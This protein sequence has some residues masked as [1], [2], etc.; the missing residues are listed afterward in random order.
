MD[1]ALRRVITA[2]VATVSVAAVCVLVFALTAGSTGGTR[3]GVKASRSKSAVSQTDPTTS[4]TWDGG[5]DGLPG[6]IPVDSRST[7]DV[8]C[9]LK[10]DFVA[11]SPDPNLPGV[12]V[13]D[14]KGTAPG[15]VVGYIVSGIDQ[16][17]PLSLTSDPATLEK[18]KV[19]NQELISREALDDGCEP[20]LKEMG[21]PRGFFPPSTDAT[22]T[23][24]TQ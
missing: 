20:L 12:P 18:L 4:T 13:Y 3:R 9:E 7:S 14:D 22:T 24:N 19:C 1:Q 2:L 6:C 21:T 10:S 5:P 8:G 16:F 15:A 11:A 23:T 17:V